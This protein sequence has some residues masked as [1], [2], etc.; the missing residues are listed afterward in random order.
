V[1]MKTGSGRFSD[2]AVCQEETDK[3]Q[4]TFGTACSRPDIGTSN[5]T[6]SNVATISMTAAPS[7]GQERT[8]ASSFQGVRESLGLWDTCPELASKRRSRTS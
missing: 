2:S 8:V 1:N 7:T 5:L 3:S 6:V 4:S